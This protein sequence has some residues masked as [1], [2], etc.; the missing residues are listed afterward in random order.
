MDT[1]KNSHKKGYFIFIAGLI[2]THGPT[3]KINTASTLRYKN[4][5]NVNN[6][7][8]GKWPSREPFNSPFPY[9]ATEK[10]KPTI[11]IPK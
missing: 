3:P 1:S 9:T 5:T 8:K 11:N 2:A 10:T 6:L 7:K 4:A